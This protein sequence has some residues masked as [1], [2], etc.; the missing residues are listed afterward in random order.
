MRDHEMLVVRLVVFGQS[1]CWAIPLAE[2]RV[3][4]FL[5]GRAVLG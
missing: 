4:E 5:L 1:R 3:L 2:F